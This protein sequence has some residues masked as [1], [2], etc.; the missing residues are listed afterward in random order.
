MRKA[1]V[2][3][4]AIAASCLTL[5]ARAFEAPAVLGLH[6]ATVHSASGF[7]NVNP[8]AYAV[9]E[10][11]FTVGTYRNSECEKF[12]AYAG[13]TW[14]TEGRLRAGITAGLVTGYRRSPFMPLLVPSVAFDLSPSTTVRLTYVPKVE[15]GG[16]HALHV[17]L[18]FPL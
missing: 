16:A 17:A 14:Q 12:S 7:C 15:K 13:W 4:A 18:E 10:G 9:W 8:G 11:G 1:V 3:A 6:L 5:P 2:I